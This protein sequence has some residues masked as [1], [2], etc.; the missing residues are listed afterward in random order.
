MAV[1]NPVA[2]RIVLSGICKYGKEA[3]YDVI[4]IIKESTFTIESNANIFKCISYILE[5]NEDAKI[6]VG[7][8]KAAANDVGLNRF[9]AQKEEIQHLNAILQLDTQLENVRIYSTQIRKLEI[10]KQL[11]I[12][13]EEAQKKLYEVQG[14]E[15]IYNIL[16]LAESTVFNFSA[17]LA[18]QDRQPVK[19]GEGI[20]EHFDDLAKNPVDSIGFQSGFP[21]WDALIGGGLRRGTINVIGARPKVGKTSLAINM[22]IH[23]ASANIP[24]LNM[25][26]EMLKTDHQYRAAASLSE[27]SILDIETGRYANNIGSKDKV[28]KALQLIKQIPYYHKS[29]AGLPLDEQLSLARRWL[30]R[31]VGLHRDGTAKDC[32]IIY[33][34]LKMMD[35]TTLTK[36]LQEYQA[37]GFMMTALHNFAVK[38][39]IAF[40]AFVQLNRDGITKEGT[41]AA[42]GSDRIIWLCSNFSIFK[43]KT[44]EETAKDGA[45]A[46]NR[47]LIPIVA[48]HGSAIEDNDYINC[49]MTGYNGRII[50]GKLSSELLHDHDD[51]DKDNTQKY[52]F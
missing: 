18:N 5:N 25:D 13:L 46:G 50:E 29:I 28:D 20:V 33:D 52:N 42:S 45:N 3:Y 22:G 51:D 12:K 31:E 49:K 2:E 23:L 27:V 11:R 7:S 36:N 37:L 14:T 17:T 1:S 30:L 4:D 26:T 44:T 24:V 9:F 19:I 48:R 34:Y 8:I 41:D 32:V 43:S 40:L 35:D 10:A 6:D 16:D 47:K 15:S 39:N 21:R 38:Y